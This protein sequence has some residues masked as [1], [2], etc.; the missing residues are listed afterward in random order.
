MVVCGELGLL[1]IAAAWKEDRKTLTVGIVN[2]TDSVAEVPVKFEGARPS[3]GGRL[4]VV[5]GQ[6]KMA[7]NEPGKTPQV[8]I[9]E[10]S[11]GVVSDRFVVPPLSVCLYALPME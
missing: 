1:D 7:Y 10:E 8:V 6:D 5:T 3:R 11:P 9:A 2:P 4:W